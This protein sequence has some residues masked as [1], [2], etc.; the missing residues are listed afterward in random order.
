[1][2]AGRLLAQHCI[3]GMPGDAA[4]R[5]ICKDTGEHGAAACKKSRARPGID[6]KSGN[7]VDIRC[8]SLDDIF[9]DG[10]SAPGLVARNQICPQKIG[11]FCV[12]DQKSLVLYA[13]ICYNRT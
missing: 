5:H 6:S 7:I 11:G 1:M 9:C 13:L 12:F 3:Y 8:R 4:H 10:K 2:S